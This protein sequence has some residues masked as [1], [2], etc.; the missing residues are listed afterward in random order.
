MNEKIFDILEYDKIK[1][2]LERFATSSPGCEMCRQLMP[3][4]EIEKIT[5][6]M[7]ETSAARERIT[8]KGKPSFAKVTKPYL[9]TEQDAR[10]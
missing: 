8:H 10:Y 5:Y 1:Q 9:A 7:N 2:M 3:E 6:L 4:I